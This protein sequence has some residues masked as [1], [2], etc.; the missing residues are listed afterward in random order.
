MR[1][2]HLSVRVLA[3]SVSAGR[4]HAVGQLRAEERRLSQ[5]DALSAGRQIAC[6]QP[7][8][9][10]PLGVRVRE[11]AA[12]L[13]HLPRRG[14][15]Q[16]RAQ[17]DGVLGRRAGRAARSHRQHPVHDRQPGVELELEIR[18]LSVPG[19]GDRRVPKVRHQAQ[20]S[21]NAG[22]SP[23][24]GAVQRGALEH[25]GVR[26]RQGDAGGRQHHDPADEVAGRQSIREESTDHQEPIRRR[27]RLVSVEVRQGA[28]G[29]RRAARSQSE[30]PGG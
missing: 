30:R 12:A 8:R 15:V 11:T 4:E 27:S 29:L 13:P 1:Q 7:G 16:D 26:R 23:A 18:P 10:R 3:G 24:K 28:Q 9:V 19:P 14:V 2:D 25:V 17:D 20:L 22:H 6:G 21:S 5:Q